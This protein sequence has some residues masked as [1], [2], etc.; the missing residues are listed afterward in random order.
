MEHNTQ[1][2]DGQ[3]A[4]TGMQGSAHAQWTSDGPAEEVLASSFPRLYFSTNHHLYA[5]VYQRTETGYLDTPFIKTP[6]YR[7]DFLAPLLE[8]PFTGGRWQRVIEDLTEEDERATLLHLSP[9]GSRLG[10]FTV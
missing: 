3:E 5:L 10:H 8:M 4:C 9:Y 1:D 7:L 6:L 2:L